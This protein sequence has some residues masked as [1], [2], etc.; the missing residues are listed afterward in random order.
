MYMMMI[1][2]MITV[3]VDFA[4]ITPAHRQHDRTEP[5]SA[6]HRLER[7][8][9]TAVECLAQ[10]SYPRRVGWRVEDDTKQFLDEPG[11]LRPDCVAQIGLSLI[12]GTGRMAAFLRICAVGHERRGR[13]RFTLMSFSH[14]QVC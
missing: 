11:L 5:I 8:T 3:D 13:H 10:A 4:L 7:T 2:T 6:G 12:Y 1:T 14:A 9:P